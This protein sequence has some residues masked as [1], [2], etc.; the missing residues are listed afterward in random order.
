MFKLICEWLIAVWR[1]EVSNKEEKR[2]KKE[3]ERL[4]IY[5]KVESGASLKWN[6][7][8][9]VYISLKQNKLLF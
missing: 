4:F 2:K 5:N 8:K 3:S 6:E 7:M 9:W 1:F